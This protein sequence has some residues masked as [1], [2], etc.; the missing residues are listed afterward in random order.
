MRPCQIRLV[1]DSIAIIVMLMIA[2]LAHES[3]AAEPTKHQLE[4]RAAKK[5]EQAKW[6][7]ARRDREVKYEACLNQCRN[8]CK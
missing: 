6:R 8:T 3:F 7:E 2:L 4:K 1:R 5:A